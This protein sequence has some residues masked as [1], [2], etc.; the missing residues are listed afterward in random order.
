MT[1]D[2]GFAEKFKS[3]FPMKAIKGLG[4]LKCVMEKVHVIPPFR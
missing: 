4:C 3:I 1:A 2:L